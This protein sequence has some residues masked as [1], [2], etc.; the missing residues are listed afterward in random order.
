MARKVKEE[1]NGRYV[2]VIKHADGVSGELT[3]DGGKVIRFATEAEASKEISKLCKDKRYSW[4]GASME[5]A[6]R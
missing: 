5:C 1:E 3:G 6:E 4:N 2:I